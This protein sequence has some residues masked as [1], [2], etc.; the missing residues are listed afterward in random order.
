MLWNMILMGYM[1]QIR[2]YWRRVEKKHKFMVKELVEENDKGKAE[3]VRL[4]VNHKDMT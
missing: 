1:H 2:L 4:D 3:E